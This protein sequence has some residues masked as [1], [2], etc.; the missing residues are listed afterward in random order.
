MTTA[1]HAWKYSRFKAI[2]SN[3]RRKK[4]HRTNQGS[5]FLGANFSNRNDVRAPI[6]FRRESQPLYL[7]RWFFL[8]KWP[9]HFQISSTSVSRPVKKKL[10]EFF[11][12]WNQQ[13]TSCPS[14]QC[15]ANQIQVQKRI[16][17]V[18]TDQIPDHTKSRK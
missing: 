12:H 11:W 7:K 1:F 9:I 2:Q 6:Q 8:K 18:A 17:I 4:L 3:F 15:L 5:N 13:V 14:P 16:L 10:V